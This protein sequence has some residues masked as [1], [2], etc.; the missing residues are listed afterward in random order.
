MRGDEGVG[1]GDE[2]RVN[3]I[4]L[5]LVLLVLF[6]FSLIFAIIIIIILNENKL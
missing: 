6:P 1:Q 4:P 5:L 2:N 3:E